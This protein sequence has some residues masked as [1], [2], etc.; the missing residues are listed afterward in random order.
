MKTEVKKM[1]EILN[2]T[3]PGTVVTHP[4][5]KNKKTNKIL[6]YG[7]MAALLLLLPEVIL[8][9]V[10][11]SPIGY[12]LKI[13]EDTLRSLFVFMCAWPGIAVILMLIWNLFRLLSRPETPS[14]EI[15]VA[16]SIAV[17]VLLGIANVWISSFAFVCTFM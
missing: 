7:G 17:I 14:R 8:S 16:L 13:E 10:V 15:K 9:C 11:F 12:F 2:Y 3:V 4:A 6:Q 1:R 5:E